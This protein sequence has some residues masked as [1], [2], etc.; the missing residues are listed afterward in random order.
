[1]FVSGRSQVFSLIVANS[2]TVHSTAP[3][4]RVKYRAVCASCS[5]DAVFRATHQRGAASCQEEIAAL[6]VTARRR[7]PIHFLL[8]VQR[9]GTPGDL[10]NTCNL[11][12]R[13]E[14]T[15]SSLATFSLLILSECMHSLIAWVLSWTDVSPISSTSRGIG[16]STVCSP[17]P[18]IARRCA[19]SHA[20][21]KPL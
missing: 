10:V 16:I 13:L 4:R 20:L 19:V 15:S 7:D 14:V 18:Q 21:V 12:R 9:V 5:R 1:M 8:I 6:R 3:E 2:Y 17:A 11:E